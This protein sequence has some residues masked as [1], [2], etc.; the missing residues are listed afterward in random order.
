MLSY[1]NFFK[2]TFFIF[3]YFT[4]HLLVKLILLL[5]IMSKKLIKW[6]RLIERIK[7]TKMSHKIETIRL[8]NQIYDK[9]NRDIIDKD[10]IDTVIFNIS[11]FL[12]NQ[13]ENEV[14]NYVKIISDL[15]L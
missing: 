2:K 14:N 8:L 1:M 6:L 13:K 15:I 7:E 9:F 10:D 12:D 4:K 5:L 3:I 11:I